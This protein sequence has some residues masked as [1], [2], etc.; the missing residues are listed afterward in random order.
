MSAPRPVSESL[1]SLKEGWELLGI[2]RSLFYK[3]LSR[4]EI[5]VVRIGHRTLVRPEALRAFVAAREIPF[6]E[7][8]PPGSGSRLR[9]SADAGGGDDEH[10]ARR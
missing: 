1:L 2:S 9:T 7:H 6:N 4:G 5:P 8:D 3:L 10:T